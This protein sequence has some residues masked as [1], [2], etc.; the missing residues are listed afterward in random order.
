MNPEQLI[1]QAG[2]KANPQMWKLALIG[3]II[4]LLMI[5]AVWISTIIHERYQRKES[6]VQEIAGKWGASQVVS[7]PFISVPYSVWEK[8]PDPNIDKPVEVIKHVYLAPDDMKITGKIETVTHKRGIFKVTGYKADLD[9]T[10]DIKAAVIDNPAYLELPLRWE[11]A[12]VCFDLEDQRGMKEINGSLNGQPLIFNRSQGVLSISSMP[13]TMGLKQTLSAYRGDSKELK[14][15]DFKLA[16]KLPVDLRTTDAKISIKVVMTGTQQLNFATSALKESVAL[17]GD[18]PAP[19]FIGDMLPESRNVNDRGFKASWQ[20]NDLNSGIKK[21]W[22]SDEPM[23]QLS[24]LGVNFLIIVD[25]YQQSTRALK[26]SALFLIL[27]FM[28]FFF[29]EIMTRQRIHSIQY[30]MVGCGLLVFYLLL[31]SISEHL[32]FG[33]AYL[34]A[35]IGVVLQISLYCYSILKTRKF[36]LQVGALLSFLYAF[37]YVLLRL[38]D[39]ALLVGSISLFVLLSVAMYIIRNVNWYNQE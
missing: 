35:A 16:A 13:E 29:A 20:T 10:A 28:T 30:L 11:E 1:K 7:G 21:L 36:A 27:T 33:W 17:E 24:N 4:L 25:S 32:A 22:S 34:I 12:V 6:V 8:N 39:S 3:L 14:N 18:W 38:Q 19:S 2:Y 15:T 26:Y 23:L 9:L 31:L 37:L 5:P